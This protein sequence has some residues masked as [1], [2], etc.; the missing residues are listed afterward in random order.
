MPRPMAVN[1]TI[2]RTRLRALG[3]DG[4]AAGTQPVA[5]DVAHAGCDD[6]KRKNKRGNKGSHVGSPKGKAKKAK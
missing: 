4:A 6:A 3:K 5:F 2:K 1:R